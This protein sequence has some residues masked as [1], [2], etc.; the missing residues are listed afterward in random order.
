MLF[1]NIALKLFFLTLKFVYVCL[2]KALFRA[3]FVLV[4]VELTHDAIAFQQLC[5]NIVIRYFKGCD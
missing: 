3:Y 4:R 2:S 1:K 5:P